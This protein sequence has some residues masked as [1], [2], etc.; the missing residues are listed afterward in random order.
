MK[1]RKVLFV[2]GASSD[3][4]VALIKHVA[5]E[6]ETI[7]AHYNTTAKPLQ[8][9]KEKLG[10]RLVMVQADFSSEHSVRCMVDTI[11][12]MSIYPDHI[13]LLAASRLIVSQFRK[14]EKKVFE[15]DMT[16]SFYSAVEILKAF[17][18]QMVKKRGGK[19]VFMLTS[20][21]IGS[22]EK[23]ISSYVCSKY[24][25][26]GLM[27]SLAVEYT[28]KGIMINAVSPD[29]INTKFLNDIPELIV[30]NNAE[31]SLV[32]RNLSVD[33]VVPTVAFL[34]SDGA[35]IISGQNIGIQ[36]ERN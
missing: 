1:D 28:E 6:Y 35:N 19:V 29:M 12:N 25:L 8:A 5:K 24:A 9:L 23:F 16:V 4:G 18:P 14:T 11:K 33:D 17:L 32:G 30:K 22:P 20:C 26:L 3:I 10:D 27:K 34:L 21:T 13:V 7:I 15:E 2:S 36:S 31:K